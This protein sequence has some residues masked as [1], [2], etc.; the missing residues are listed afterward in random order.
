M[1]DIFGPLEVAK[2]NFDVLRPLFLEVKDKISLKFK[3]LKIER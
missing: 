3:F 1:T 2:F